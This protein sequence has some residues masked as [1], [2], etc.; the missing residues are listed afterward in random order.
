MYASLASLLMMAVVAATP[1]E[2]KFVQVSPTFH[3]ADDINRSA[4]ENRAVVLIQGLCIHPFSSTRVDQA[5]WQGWQRSESALV[6]TL[7]K[8][9]DMF[10][11]CYGQNLAVEQVAESSQL[12][13][14]LDR[15][16][17]IGYTEIVLVG[18][19]AGG[20]IA[21]HFV[22]DHPDAGV[23]KVIQVCSPNGGSS[24]G[25]AEL[26]VRQGQ[27]SF[28]GSLTRQGR[29]C[30]LAGRCQKKIPDNVEF[31][32]LVGHYEL[33]LGVNY[34]FAVWR[35]RTVT[36]SVNKELRGDGIVSSERQ[37]PPD[38]QQQRIPVV[39]LPIDH[40]RA[41]RSRVAINKIADLIREK[42]PRLAA[43]EVEKVRLQLFRNPTDAEVSVVLN[44][45]SEPRSQ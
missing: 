33:Q 25:N 6:K 43:D 3:E 41:V 24:W 20:L 5:D 18:H 36:I 19:S 17:E 39:V 27:E 14:H 8:D 4:D 42:Q 7:A 21:R 1:V 38:L 44:G 35:G 45:V 13:C 26:G 31:V 10:A 16:K 9:S 32:C 34:S 15:L 23:T 2:M 29:E 40:V 22:E 37:W 11:V 28:L 12:V 30:C